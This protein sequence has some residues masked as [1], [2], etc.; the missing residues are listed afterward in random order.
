ML[1]NERMALKSMREFSLKKRDHAIPEQEVHQEEKR[2]HSVAEHVQ[3][4]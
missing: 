3:S 2:K 4:Q 1:P